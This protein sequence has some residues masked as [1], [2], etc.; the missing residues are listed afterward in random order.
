MCWKE[1]KQNL[2]ANSCKDFTIPLP[3]PMEASLPGLLG[4]W[5][6]LLLSEKSIDRAEE[7][8]KV[9]KKHV[10]YKVRLTQLL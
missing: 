4:Q 3:F 6:F 7:I 8:L 10:V 1:E 5:R 9:D 2:L